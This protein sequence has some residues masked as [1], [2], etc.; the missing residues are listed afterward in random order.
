MYL[1][2]L[3]SKLSQG[4]IFA[5]IPIVDSADPALKKKD[6]NVIILSH[7]CD[8]DK[9]TQKIVL[10]CAIRP[11]SELNPGQDKDIIKG[12]IRNAMH[13]KPVGEMGDSFIDFRFTF[14]VNKEFLQEAE[15]NGAKIASLMDDAQL[16]LIEYFRRFLAR[17]LVKN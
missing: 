13:V 9:P 2:E 16:A 12:R 14:R 3:R 8:I 11:F 4:D 15:K 1:P 7:T 6:Y 17:D 10:V 5:Q